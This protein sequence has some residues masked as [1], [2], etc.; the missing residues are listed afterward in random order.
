[1]R[2]KFPK[3]YPRCATKPVALGSRNAL[4]LKKVVT[5]AGAENVPSAVFSVQQVPPLVAAAKSKEEAVALRRDCPGTRLNR[6]QPLYPGMNSKNCP[7]LQLKVFG[8]PLW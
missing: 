7:P 5:P 3:T 4:Q 2:G 6:R 1:M 8:C